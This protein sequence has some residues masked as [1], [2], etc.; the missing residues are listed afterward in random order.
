M[1]I[2]RPASDE[3]RLVL[4]WVGRAVLGVGA[5]M[6]LP[7]AVALLCGEWSAAPDFLVGAAACAALWLLTENACRT[8]LDL[9]WS[10]GMVAAS[11][12]WPAAMLLGAV[13]SYLS[14]HYAS[15]LDACFDLMSGCTTT[16]LT[17]VQDLDHASCA[18]NTWRHLL[19]Y[20]GGLGAAAVAL[21]LFLSGG[22]GT[23][24]AGARGGGG[25]RP[26]PAALRA[27]RTVW[28][29]SLTYLAA[30][31]LALWLVLALEG[32]PPGRGLLQGAWLC[33]G[34]WST[35]GFAPHSLN[36]M[37]YQSLPVELLTMLLFT[38]GSFSFALHWAVWNGKRREAWR[39]VELRSMGIT[40]CLGAAVMALGLSKAGVFRGLGAFLRRG[41]FF[42]LSGHTTAGYGNALPSSLSG[43]FGLVAFWG[44]IMVMMV[45]ASACS[46]GGGLKGL[47]L[48]VIF[49]S[50]WL[51]VKRVITPEY[52]VLSA[53]VRHVGDIWLDD[54]LVGGVMLVVICYMV[55]FLAG[56]V[57]GIVYRYDF[58]A[59]FFEA[60]SAGSNT[61][62]SCGLTAP[63]MPAAMKVGYILM[64]W[65]GRLEFTAVFALLGMAMALVRGKGG[66][67]R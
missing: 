26:L 33:M 16:G 53:K 17:L 60:V 31:T 2:L 14:G 50:L 20:A 18:L 9:G 24:R 25:E 7:L 40:L 8:R 36:L 58:S 1:I 15:F 6:L 39:D 12:A 45:G 57:L 5:L 51:E 19:T 59:S 23:F 42:L 47:R 38:L 29:V 67:R 10:H 28:T 61:G 46:T 43:D 64:M 41:L 52:S 34:A 30:G 11:L 56:A 4:F 66:R 49:K 35:G 22:V 32:M 63:A 62:L 65:A 27:S 55:T 37:Y 44:L 21:A 54:A 48:G 13:P 3:V